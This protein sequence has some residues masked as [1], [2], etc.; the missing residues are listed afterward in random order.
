MC[1]EKGLASLQSKV[2]SPSLI[3]YSNIL[4]KKHKVLH[5][6][7]NALKCVCQFLIIIRIRGKETQ[8][9]IKRKR[10]LKNKLLF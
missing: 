7:L 3:N 5:V 10:N 2:G 6:A 4:F 9:N 1:D 8:Y